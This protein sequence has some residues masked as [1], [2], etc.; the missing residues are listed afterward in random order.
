MRPDIPPEQF[1]EWLKQLPEEAIKEGNAKE[2]Q[3]SE[4]DWKKFVD[5][6]NKGECSLCNKPLKTFSAGSP[7]LRRGKEQGKFSVPLKEGKAKAAELFN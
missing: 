3:Q 7:C 2:L 5:Y 4:E 1:A 6:F